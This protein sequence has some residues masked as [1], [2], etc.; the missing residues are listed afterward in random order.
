MDKG[1]L[2]DVLYLDFQ[3]AFDKELHQKLLWQVKAHG[4]MGNI[5]AGIEDWLAYR[6]QERRHE[7]VFFWLTGCEEWCAT[8]ISAGPSIFYNLYK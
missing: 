2:L 3:K 6:K 7:W 4:V 1:E 8:E 5:L